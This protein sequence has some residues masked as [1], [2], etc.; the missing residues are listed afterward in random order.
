LK[1]IG[2]YFGSFNPIHIG[3]LIVAQSMIDGAGIDEVWFVVSPQNPFKKSNTLIHEFDR[4]EM[5]RLAIH[6][7]FQFSVSDIE[8]SMPKPSYTI[9]TLTYLQDKYPSH[10]FFLIIGQ[11]NL[12]QFGNWKNHDKILEFFHLLVYPRANCANSEFDHHPKVRWVEA[13]L[14]NISATYIRSLI[15]EGKSLRYLV[16]LPV[17]DYIRDKKLWR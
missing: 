13:P 6:D 7:N 1:K 14:L 16:P 12:S 11:D 5:V 15:S 2:L 3:H 9:D 10:S 17:Q 8:F 4:Y